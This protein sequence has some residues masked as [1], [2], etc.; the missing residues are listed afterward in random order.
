MNRKVKIFNERSFLDLEKNI[1]SFAKNHK[2]IQVSYNFTEYSF[3]HCMV[4]YEEY[5]DIFVNL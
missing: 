1:N 2:I 3:F 5:D 4:L